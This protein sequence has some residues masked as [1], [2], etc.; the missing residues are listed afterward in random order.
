[1][2]WKRNTW[3]ELINYINNRDTGVI[4]RQNILF[5]NNRSGAYTVDCYRNY[6]TKA[7]FLQVETSGTY[8]R[9]KEIPSNLTI[10]VCKMMAYGQ[11]TKTG[12]TKKDTRTK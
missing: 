10:A 7:G 2:A 1:M 4:L 9:V 12:R 3:E 5:L 6:L 11:R 8:K